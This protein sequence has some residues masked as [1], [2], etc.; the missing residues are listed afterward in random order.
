MGRV[1]TR[2]DP[3]THAESYGYDSAGN[4]SHT[5]RK[6]QVTGRI[7]DG[8]NRLTQ[9]TYADTSTSTYPWDAGNRLTEI[10]D[11]PS[12]TI[13]RSYDGLDRLTQEVTPRGTNTPWTTSFEQLLGRADLAAPLT[14][15]IGRSRP[16]VAERADRRLG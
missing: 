2:T 1:A 6:S 13:T 12:G 4:L 11:S 10:V 8:L 16:R 5:D 15:P 3:L 14:R 7:Y 9:V